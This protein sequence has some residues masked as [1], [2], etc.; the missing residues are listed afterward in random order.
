MVDRRQCHHAFHLEGQNSGYRFTL[1]FFFPK[2][3]QRNLTRKA[4]INHRTFERSSRL[5][6][7]QDIGEK[8]L[9]FPSVK[10]EFAFKYT[11]PKRNLKIHIM[12]EVLNPTQS[13]NG[14]RE[15]HKTPNNG[16]CL[17]GIPSLQLKSRKAIPDYISRGTSE[18][19][20]NELREGSQGERTSHLNVML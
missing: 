16:K 19:S 17:V 7:L 18:K 2:N 20:A 1:Q 14:F 6:L 4:K 8:L 3:H 13:W 11:S 9:S 10:G 12:G 15:Q 5:Q